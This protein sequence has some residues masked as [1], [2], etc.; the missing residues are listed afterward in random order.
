M[1]GVIC[2]GYSDDEK[3]AEIA[4]AV[5]A[6]GVERV[7]VL[8]GARFPLALDLPV[9]CEAHTWEDE[10]LIRYTVFY[11]LLREVDDRT[12]IVVNE[13]LRSQDRHALDYNCVRNYLQQT[14]HA[15]VFQRVPIIDTLD[16]F[17]VLFDFATRS[18]WKR[19]KVTP[20]LLREVELRVR[21]F[22]PTLTALP[23]AVD[24]KTHD[25]YAREKAKLL[26]EIGLRDP[27]TIPRTL[28]LMG[29]KA[30][31]RHVVEGARYVGRN[32]RLA[33]PALDTYR[34]A[35]PDRAP[36]TAF[37]FC[38]GFLDFADFVSATGQ[39]DVRALV[40]DLK[41]DGWYFDRF[42]QWCGRVRDACAVLRG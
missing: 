16:D 5:A 35:A 27:H 11:R 15:L 37:E 38:H 8:H 21:P 14:K 19:E 4:R 36:Y 30:K 31:A 34:E 20:A 26:A 33:L 12:L 1:E 2:V 9:P 29:G 41:V 6:S 18:R 13:L 7:I 10:G 23:V 42:E 17:G 40:S 22:T 24:G 25:A 39:T 3:R 32:N 28:H